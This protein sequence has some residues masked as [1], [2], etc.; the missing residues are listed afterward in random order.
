[1]RENVLMRFAWPVV[2]LAVILAAI[3]TP[4]PV[5]EAQEGAG[6]GIVARR[7]EVVFPAVVRLFVTFEGMDEPP[8]SVSLLLAQDDRV[9]FDEQVE[10]IAAPEEEGTATWRYDWPIPPEDGPALFEPVSYRW[11]VV[12]S[13]DAEQEAD[14]EFVF[15]PGPGDFRHGGEPPLSFTVLD[16]SL[17]LRLARQ[18]V[19]PAYELMAAQTGLE[20]EFR[21]VVLPPGFAYCTA[22][23]DAEGR[24]VSVVLA[25]SPEEEPDTYP[26]R[27]DAAE[28]LFAASGYQVLWRE[29]AGLLQF[30]DAL[31]D[32]MFSVFY[33]QFWEGQ[34]IPDWFRAGLRRYLRVNPDPLLIRRLQIEARAGRLFTAAQMEAE[35]SEPGQWQLWEQQAYGLVLYLADQHGAEAPLTLA[36]EA[37]QTAWDD[38][39]GDP[40]GGDLAA[41]MPNWERWL[42]VEGAL[43]AGSWT[44]YMPDTPTPTPTRTAT[45]LP[46]TAA[47]SATATAA[48]S[49]AATMT[50]GSAAARTLSPLPA[51][52]TPTP[53]LTAT[54]TPRPPG[55]LTQPP[56]AR[57][58]PGGGICPATLPSLLLPL[59]AIAIVQ[60]RK[61]TP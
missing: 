32:A 16:S 27:E 18:A 1:M 17:N 26:C 23:T 44:L 5:V 2:L 42:F 48:A 34:N 36:Q 19:L 59:G 4:I 33:G 46:P 24:T 43:R 57:P 41:L 50:P 10:L 51:T 29:K 35:P 47:P 20:P 13:A 45:P 6:Q 15:A 12:D 52:M 9:F 7:V 60:R 49:P 21:W 3:L 38:A 25:P 39:F 37:A 58:E 31:V 61:K 56:P 11:T 8:E 14:G 40:T 54:N 30:E 55:S 53:L 22:T 28:R